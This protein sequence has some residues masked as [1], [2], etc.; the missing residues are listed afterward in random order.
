M[1][2]KLTIVLL[3]LNLALAGLI[4]VTQSRQAD[5]ELRRHSRLVFPSG[6]GDL[7]EIE[8]RPAVGGG[9]TLR[10][11]R[12]GWHLSQPLEWPANRHAVARLVSTLEF[13]E[14]ESVFSLD[15]AI[16]AGRALAD[17]GLEAP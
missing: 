9:W 3:I 6:L 17:Y 10:Q 7:D 16:A 14:K 8:L 12:D 2:F 1:R 13:L 15:E 11:R 5:Q 4:Y